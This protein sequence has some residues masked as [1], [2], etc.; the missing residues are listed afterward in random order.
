M[1]ENDLCG[2][3]TQ[4]NNGESDG[5]IEMTL[6]QKSLQIDVASAAGIV[7]PKVPA[8]GKRP[9]TDVSLCPMAT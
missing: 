6:P 3:I 4:N 1:I 2:E 8:M 7:S 5:E 9:S